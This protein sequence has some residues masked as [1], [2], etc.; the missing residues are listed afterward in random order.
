MSR[1]LTLVSKCTQVNEYLM[2]N[3]KVRSDSQIRDSLNDQDTVL[4]TVHGSFLTGSPH[5]K[6]VN[7][8]DNLTSEFLFRQIH[9]EKKFPKWLF[10]PLLWV[11]QQRQKYQSIISTSVSETRLCITSKHAVTDEP[12]TIWMEAVMTRYYPTCLELPRTTTNTMSE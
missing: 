1:S 5:V 6:G 9:R 3:W 4:H 7:R 8:R 10:S 12:E 11:I 2:N